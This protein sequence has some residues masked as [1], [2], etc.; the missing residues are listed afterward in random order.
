MFSLDE[1]KEFCRSRSNR[2]PIDQFNDSQWNYASAIVSKMTVFDEHHM[3]KA[4]ANFRRSDRPAF[5]RNVIELLVSYMHWKH[6]VQRKTHDV[7]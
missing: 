2:H 3:N 5:E 1:F 4:W 7:H 6:Q